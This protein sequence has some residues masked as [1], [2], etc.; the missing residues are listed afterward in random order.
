M[1]EAI[2]IVTFLVAG[3]FVGILAERLKPK[4][5]SSWKQG[6]ISGL[7]RAALIVDGESKRR[8][9]QGSIRIPAMVGRIKAAITKEADLLEKRR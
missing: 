7:R 1:I 8:L 6:Y 9:G 5:V 4:E 3:Y 2:L